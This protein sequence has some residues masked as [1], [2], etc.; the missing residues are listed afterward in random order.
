MQYETLKGERELS[1]NRIFHSAKTIQ[2]Y[3]IAK[4]YRIACRDSVFQII[5]LQFDSH[6]KENYILAKNTVR[7]AVDLGLAMALQKTKQRLSNP[8]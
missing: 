2:T 6:S 5:Y 1:I 3:Q 4:N 8:Y 7:R